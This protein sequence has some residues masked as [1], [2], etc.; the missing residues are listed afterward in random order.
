[1]H[2]IGNKSKVELTGTG[3]VKHVNWVPSRLVKSGT[4]DK[5]YLI[6]KQIMWFQRD[7]IKF[8]NKMKANNQI[9]IK[10]GIN[11]KSKKYE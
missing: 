6:L 2:K 7:Q 5:S 1:M 4:R 9:L 8:T 11:I 3:K 10:A